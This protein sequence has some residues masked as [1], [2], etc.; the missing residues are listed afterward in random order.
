MKLSGIKNLILVLLAG[1][2]LS[3]TFRLWF[4]SFNISAALSAPNNQ[5]QNQSFVIDIPAL[6]EIMVRPARIIRHHSDNFFTVTYSDIT[7]S[8]EFILGSQ[9]IGEVL[10][11]GSHYSSAVIGDD[12][13]I[14]M[15]LNNSIIF[16]YNFSMPT[17]IFGSFFGQRGSLLSSQTSGFDTLLIS[18]DEGSLRLVFFNRESRQNL[19]HTFYGE[20]EGLSRIFA[21]LALQ[22]EA[23]G[24]VSEPVL[25]YRLSLLCFPHI[26]DNITFIP[27]WQGDLSFY[28]LYRHVPYSVLHL[29]AIR[30]FV[31]FLFP[32]PYAVISS[33]INNVFTYRDGYRTVMFYPSNVMTYSTTNRRDAQAA[34]TFTSSYFAAL[35]MVQRDASSMASLGTPMNQVFLSGYHHI[36][37]SNEWLFFFDYVADNLPIRFAEEF[38]REIML[39]HGIEVRVRGNTVVHYRRLLNNFNR[40]EAQEVSIANQS[41]EDALRILASTYDITTANLQFRITAESESILHWRINPNGIPQSIPVYFEPEEEF[42]GY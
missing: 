8:P 20:S 34:A 5:S 21:G 11:N 12:E 16:E 29:S 24:A 25:L 19:V 10:R 22:A 36:E 4:G 39:S 27:Y 28:P 9:I 31:L 1:F 7:A 15:F 41:F 37:G 40:N 14:Q 26:F 18:S 42:Y 33:N 13:L 38:A 3:L 32:N 35:D 6:T 2:C 17:D 30:R 23:G